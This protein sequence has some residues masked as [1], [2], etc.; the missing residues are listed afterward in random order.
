MLVFFVHARTRQGDDRTSTICTFSPSNHSK[1]FRVSRK[2]LTMMYEIPRGH[3]DYFT[4]TPGALSLQCQL[5]AVSPQGPRSVTLDSAGAS[6]N[7]LPPGCIQLSLPASP[8][9]KRASALARQQP[10]DQQR[11]SSSRVSSMV[12]SGRSA[13]P[14][15]EQR[16][17][18]RRAAR[19]GQA[20][21]GPG[22]PCVHH[23]R[24][25]LRCRRPVGRRLET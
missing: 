16:R 23:R 12:S 5:S 9:S 22:P 1:V 19:Q 10:Y 3:I 14:P 20:P 4:F 21:S 2:I 18:R 13:P 15:Q 7:E 17:R 24:A 6:A 25:C 8:R 11:Y